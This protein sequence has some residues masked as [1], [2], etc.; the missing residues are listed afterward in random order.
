MYDLKKE[1]RGSVRFCFY[2]NGELYYATDSGF[3]F[4]VPTSDTGDAAFLPIDRA[5]LFMRWL[6]P[7]IEAAN[8]EVK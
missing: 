8:T 1:L 7:A 3:C 4:T 5:M 6:R 2:R